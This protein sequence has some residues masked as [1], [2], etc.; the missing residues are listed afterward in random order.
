MMGNKMI[1]RCIVLMVG[2]GYASQL[3]ADIQER[4][5]RAELEKCECWAASDDNS[6]EVGKVVLHFSDNPMINPLPSTIYTAKNDHIYFIA[7][8]DISRDQLRSV[9]EAVKKNNNKWY[10]LSLSVEKKPIPGIKLVFTY[11]P[12][13][14]SVTHLSFDTLGMQK[15]VSFRLYNKALINKLNKRR[16]R[17]LLCIAQLAPFSV[18]A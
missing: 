13:K 16:E 2:I 11:D 9:M 12:E 3:H 10:K 5:S 6:L 4:K 17:P 1:E 18:T 8:A 14:V 7:A 15:G